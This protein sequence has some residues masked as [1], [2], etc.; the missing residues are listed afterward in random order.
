M[1]VASFGGRLA[2][3]RDPIGRA[4]GRAGGSASDGIG[5][6][7]AA[8]GSRFDARSL[9]RRRCGHRAADSGGLHGSAPVAAVVEQVAAERRRHECLL[10]DRL[11]A[12][13]A[14]T[15]TACGR[16]VGSGTMCSTLTGFAFGGFTL[17]TATGA[18]VCFGAVLR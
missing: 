4:L 3:T 17:A 2:T 9:I 1:T 11:G 7:G 10:R 16:A 13:A 14:A 15:A 12:A 5:K 6:G 8:G 18:R